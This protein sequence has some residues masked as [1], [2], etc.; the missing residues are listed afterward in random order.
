MS[1]KRHTYIRDM[2]EPTN[3]ELGITAE[4]EIGAAIVCGCILGVIVVGLALVL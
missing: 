1:S 3:E 2:D 4:I